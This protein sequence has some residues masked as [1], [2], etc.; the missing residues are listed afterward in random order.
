MWRAAIRAALPASFGVTRAPR[1]L[2]AWRGRPGPTRWAASAA[3]EGHPLRGGKVAVVTGAGRG[4]GLEFTRQ[5]LERGNSVC[6]LYRTE[7]AELEALE[8]S[9]GGRLHTFQVDLEDEASILAACAGVAGSGVERVDALFNVAG[10]LHDKSRSPSLPE[11]ALARIKMDD[12]V[13]GFKINAIAPA[14][15]AGNL[16]SLLFKSDRA[17][18]VNLSA[19][20]GSVTDNAVGGW[21]SYRASKSAVN[22]LTKTMSIEFTNRKRPVTAIA[23]HPGTCD[24]DLS[25]PYTKNYKNP[26]FPKELAVQQLLDVVESVRP[27]EQQGVFLDW[28]GKPVPW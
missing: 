18:V 26:V 11:T 12:A 8:A 4:L 1:A 13:R 23:L 5:L 6:A 27:V 19:R 24:T 15:L 28:E 17:I 25:A 9:G 20:V 10:L 21:Y 3:H 7:S 22:S 2:V 16:S 14:L